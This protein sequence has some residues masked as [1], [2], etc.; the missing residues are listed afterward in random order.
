MCRTTMAWEGYMVAQEGY[1]HFWLQKV[2]I[3]AD[4]LYLKC[5]KMV[6]YMQCH[7][8]TYTD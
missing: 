1:F 6:Q 5:Y 7:S 4:L 2:I 3:S 8:H